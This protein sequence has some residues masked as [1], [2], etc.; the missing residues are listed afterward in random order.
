MDN[1]QDPNSP[2]STEPQ[3]QNVIPDPLRKIIYPADDPIIGAN[4]VTVTFTP[5]LNEQLPPERHVWAPDHQAVDPAM[6][7]NKIADNFGDIIQSKVATNLLEFNPDVLMHNSP[8]SPSGV[9]QPFSLDSLLGYPNNLSP[10]TLGVSDF[11]DATVSIDPNPPSRWYDLIIDRALAGAQQNLF[12]DADD[13]DN[14]IE[15]RPEDA[16]QLGGI[17]AWGGNDQVMGTP[18][19]DT[20]NGNEG[21]DQIFGDGGNDLLLGGPGDDTLVG[22]DGSDILVGEAGSDVLIGNAGD[23]ILITDALRANDKGDFLIGST[24]ADKFILRS[25]TLTNDAAYAHRILDFNPDEGD[26]II[27][28]GFQGTNQISLASV[29]VNQDGKADTAILCSDGVFG[30]IMSK[31]PSEI[32]PT[33]SI[34][35]LAPENSTLTKIS[36]FSRLS[37]EYLSN[38][39]PVSGV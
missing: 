5:P 21:N 15:I 36:D 25:N 16:Q 28:A 2:N 9:T 38:P 37:S 10:I 6:D 33:S 39:N 30:V 17:R 11:G 22:G 34:F 19:S 8:K 27:I 13:E 1:I 7:L 18:N 29:N 35:M 12:V 23:D 4:Y 24:G 26:T 3:N 14:P 20:A 31:D 32:T